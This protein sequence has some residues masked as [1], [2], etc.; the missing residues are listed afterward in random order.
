[1]RT[2]LCDLLE[3]EHP[4]VQAPIG[5]AAV[6][7]LAAAVSNAGALGTLTISWMPEERITEVVRA[8]KALTDRPFGVNLM[9]AWDQRSRLDAALEAGAPVVSLAWSEPQPEL[10]RQA[11]DGGALVLHTIG[12]AAEA[13]RAVEAGADGVVTQGWESGGHVWSE[14]ATMPLVPAVVDAVPSGTPVVAAGGIAD[15]RG[16][17]AALALGAAGAWL[18]TRFM[19]AEEAPVHPTYRERLLEADET[20]AVYTPDL[21]FMEFPDAP[22]RTLRNSTYENWVAAG[23]PPPGE[24]PGEG[25]EIAQRADG[26][27][28]PRYAPAAPLEGTTGDVAALA[29]WAGQSV[30]LVGRLQP[31]A[32][33]VRELVDE[34]RQVLRALPTE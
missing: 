5:S 4:I 25:E 3:I 22:H 24:R 21:Y 13:R 30:G 17:A 1:V 6:P 34:T 2:A 33:I 10:I 27:R 11:H 8:T 14:V 12:S 18:G 26:I 15:G 32:E 16:V 7:E 31:A 29:L 9:L 23:R 20:D 19:L 28:L